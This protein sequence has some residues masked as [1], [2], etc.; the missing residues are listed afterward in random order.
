MKRTLLIARHDFLTNV[1]RRS[2]LFSAFG[3]PL[4]IIIAQFAIGAFVAEQSETTGSLGTIGYVDH[5]PDQV[6][7]AA[8]EKPAEYRAYA[9]EQTARAALLDGEIGAYFVV[10]DDYVARGVVH[11]YAT[12]DVPRGIESQMS[13]FLTRNLLTDWP[14]ERVDRLQNPLNL[15]Y[16]TLGGEQEIRDDESAVAAVLVPLFFAIILMMSIFTTSGFLLRGVVEEKENRM[17]EILVT[18]VTPLQMLWGKIL[19]L[20]VLGLVQIVVWGAAGALTLTQ[21]SNFLPELAS[22]SIPTSMLIWGPIYL[23]LGYLLYGALL[24]GIG[25]SV[26]SMAEG[27]QVSGIV[28]LVAVIPMFA[29]SSFFENANGTLPVLTSLFPFTAPVAMLVRLSLA[30]VPPWQIGLSVLLMGVGALLIVW[31]AAQVFRVGLLMYGKRLSPRA[32]WAALRQG[33]DVIPEGQE[34]VAQ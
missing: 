32:L 23:L 12:R 4:L 3:L 16:A 1:K 22:V 30:D 27:Q 26:T 33:L 5:T 25:A 24:A 6:L 10:P 2:F 21:G 17:I 29:M 13:S 11:V 7:N 15:S 14:A 31:I 28:S 8:V 18:S 19:G 9:Q 34:E 20:G